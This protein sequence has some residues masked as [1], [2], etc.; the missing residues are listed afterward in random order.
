MYKKIK[1]LFLL[2]NNICNSNT[3]FMICLSRCFFFYFFGILNYFLQLFLPRCKLQCMHKKYNTCLE[4]SLIKGGLISKS[5][6]LWL[7]SAKNCTK[8]DLYPPK[9]KMPRIVFGIFLGDW[10]QLSEIKPP[11]RDERCH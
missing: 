6:S 10:S 5:F 11:L 9:E 1:N 7:Q 3:Y 8:S 4:M 2:R